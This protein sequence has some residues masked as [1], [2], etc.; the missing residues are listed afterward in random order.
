MF[1]ERIHNANNE[2]ES[3]EI[4]MYGIVIVT[5]GL[6]AKGFVD[7]VKLIVGI[8]DF[9]YTGLHEGHNLDYF[10]E[11]L[12]NKII[13]QIEQYKEVIVLTDLMYGTPFNTVSRL[14][15]KY[16]FLHIT[17]INLPLLLEIVTSRGVLSLDEI[18]Q[19]IEEEKNNAVICVNSLLEKVNEP[20]E[21]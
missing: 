4:H 8:N 7:A 13:S 12:E 10:E 17:G 18:K 20:N 9:P 15:E 14:M 1:F 6:L 19:R 21:N 2:R 16:N 11:D 3:E 5:H